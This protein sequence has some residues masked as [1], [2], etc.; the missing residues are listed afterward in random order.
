[1]GDSLNL[2]NSTHTIIIANLVATATLCTPLDRF[3]NVSQWVEQQG[4]SKTE[5]WV[6]TT[7]NYHRNLSLCLTNLL[8]N[9]VTLSYILSYNLERL[10]C[11][12]YVVCSSHL[13]QEFTPFVGTAGARRLSAQGTRAD[14][15]GEAIGSSRGE[16]RKI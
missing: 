6:G 16:F 12:I 9:I 14:N 13:Y 15:R 10:L 7:L 1:M 4:L 2:T 5:V 11:L 8:E 3:K